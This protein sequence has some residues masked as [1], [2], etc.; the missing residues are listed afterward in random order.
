MENTIQDYRWGSTEALAR[1]CGRRPHGGHEAELWLG[2]HP[3]ASSRI[4]IDGRR[5]ALIDVIREDPAA[6]LGGATT[7]DPSQHK[8]GLPY[9]C[10]MLAASEP[11]SIQLHPGREAATRG[12]DRE[13]RAGIPITAPDRN[14]RDRNHKPELICA[15]E[16]F[17]ALQGFRDHDELAAEMAAL[18]A[19]CSDRDAL[20]GVAA[21]LRRYA[22]RPNT[23]TWRDAFTVLLRQSQVE[24][25]RGALAVTVVRYAQSRADGD[26]TRRYDWVQRIA[27]FFPGD[28]GSAAPL[29]LNLRHLQPGQALFLPS[30]TLHA[31]LAGVGVEIMAGSDNVLR[32]GCTTK[33]IDVEEFLA[34]ATFEPYRS[35]SDAGH[36]EGPITRYTTAAREFEL[37]RIDPPTRV[38]IAHGAAILLALGSSVTVRDDAAGHE[39]GPGSS[40]FV[41]PGTPPLSLQGAGALYVAALPAAVRPA[42]RLGKR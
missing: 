6:W 18:A 35:T 22:R 5:R 28:P 19:A 7:H 9:L 39:L 14:Y 21:A 37:C 41:Q 33:H 10:K 31:Y 24:P 20:A 30:R 16:E 17:W 1:L 11:L 3:K 8:R 15:I 36:P 4:V 13:E 2:A 29:Y 32:A 27:R 38:E 23:A 25:T 12:F 34:N 26:P 42:P 40:L